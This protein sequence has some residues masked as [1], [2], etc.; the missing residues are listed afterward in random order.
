MGVIQMSTPGSCMDEQ[1][2]LDASPTPHSGLHRLEKAECYDAS[3]NRKEIETLRVESDSSIGEHGRATASVDPF[4]LAYAHIVSS[5]A[6]FQ[7]PLEPLASHRLQETEFSNLLQAERTPTK[8]DES[9][10]DQ[11]TVHTLESAARMKEFADSPISPFVANNSP[12]PVIISMVRDALKIPLTD[13]DFERQRIIFTAVKDKGIAESVID[14][15]VKVYKQHPEVLAKGFDSKYMQRRSRT[16]RHG[17]IRRPLNS[18]M[19]YRRVQTYLFHVVNPDDTEFEKVNHQSVSIVIGQFWKTE[20]SRVK[21][22]FANLS[23]I[24]ST[25]HRSLHPDYKYRPHK[26]SRLVPQSSQV[27]DF[28][29]KRSNISSE[30]SQLRYG[31]GNR[32]AIYQS[33]PSTAGFIL[34]RNLTS[35]FLSDTMQ[36]ED[37][38]VSDT[39]AVVAAATGGSYNGSMEACSNLKRLAATRAAK[40]RLRGNHDYVDDQDADSPFL[41]SHLTIEAT[42]DMHMPFRQAISHPRSEIKYE[43]VMVHGYKPIN[44]VEDINGGAYSHVMCGYSDIVQDEQFQRPAIASLEHQAGDQMSSHSVEHSRFT[45]PTPKKPSGSVS[46]MT[47]PNHCTMRPPDLNP[48]SD[49]S[50]VAS[51][52]VAYSPVT[53]ND[54]IHC[55]TEKVYYPQKEIFDSPRMSGTGLGIGTM[56]QA[57]MINYS[58]FPET[59][60][61]VK[62]PY[63]GDSSSSSLHGAYYSDSPLGHGYHPYAPAFT[64]SMYDGEYSSS[65]SVQPENEALFVNNVNSTNNGMMQDPNYYSMLLNVYGKN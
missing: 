15:M 48:P 62:P 32:A 8:S 36:A 21:D 14:E 34:P 5:S 3:V 55:H 57:F 26:K 54:N 60:S 13:M 22:A 37:D 39:A 46:V 64:Q 35:V 27:A 63:H 24:E 40:N 43:D 58:R 50:Y 38:L 45:L 1:I 33:D 10:T 20:N 59:Q 17:H 41:T 49:F 12:S 29:I 56:P 42:R 11:L 4:V 65:L 51:S 6:L 2:Q 16:R 31:I 44:E 7:R 23:K 28:T 30:D 47:P 52:P 18:F 53:P 61:S 25:L 9:I 19:L